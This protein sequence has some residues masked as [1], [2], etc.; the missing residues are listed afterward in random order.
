MK[1][2]SEILQR[3]HRSSSLRHPRTRT[4][5]IMTFWPRTRASS[6]RE[7]EPHPSPRSRGSS[8]L[9]TRGAT[10]SMKGDSDIMSW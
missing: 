4:F 9:T 7:D 1:H 2:A 6:T 8:P 5:E 3:S 10:F